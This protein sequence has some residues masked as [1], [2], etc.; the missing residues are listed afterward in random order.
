MEVAVRAEDA[1]RIR[2]ELGKRIG[3]LLAGADDDGVGTLLGHGLP[4]GQQHG[5][6]FGHL[7]EAGDPAAHRGRDG[8]IEA[9]GV[10][11]VP[12]P[13]RGEGEITGDGFAERASDTGYFAIMELG[14]I[15]MGCREGEFVGV[16]AEQGRMPGVVHSDAAREDTG[17]GEVG[18][19]V[20]D[21]GAFPRD[22]LDGGGICLLYTSPSPRD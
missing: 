9:H 4:D 5:G 7:D 20:V 15:E 1:Q 16:V 17:R 11:Q 3:S 8:Q 12:V 22:R 2:G 6:M 21:S 10:A 18:Y 13:V 14:G 19:H